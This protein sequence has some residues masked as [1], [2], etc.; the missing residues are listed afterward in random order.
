MSD[1]LTQ[2]NKS[3]PY[4]F[5]ALLS[6]FLLVFAAAATTADEV[7]FTIEE[8]PLAIALYAFAR[9]CDREILF[10]TDLVE[11]K[12][13]Q[14]VEGIYEPEAALALIL[15]DSG[16]GYSVTD[17]DTFLVTRSNQQE[18]GEADDSAT[19]EQD[20]GME[21]PQLLDTIVV[22]GTRL[23][24]PN[25]TSPVVVI[26]REAIDA[27]GFSTAE[28]V[29]RSLPQNFSTMNSARSVT[30]PV[31][32]NGLPVGSV[33]QGESAANLRALGS[34]ATLVLVNGR[35]T[36]SSAAFDGSQVNL[37]GIPA[38]AIDRVEV[39]LDGASAVYGSD[40]IG[41]V[42]NF[43]LRED[44]VGAT[45]S[46]SFENSSTQSDKFE[47]SQLAGFGWHGG[48]LTATISYSD[49]DPIVTADTGFTTLDY[50]SRGGPDGRNAFFSQPGNVF[51]IGALPLD[52]DGTSWTLADLSPANQAAA[53]SDRVPA[54]QTSKVDTL[55]LMMGLD[56]EIGDQSA[57]FADLHYSENDT[58]S[59]SGPP[60][61]FG[62]VP[63]N[64]PYNNAG[65]PLFVASDHSAEA[66]AGL[67]PLVSQSVVSSNLNA[68]AGV[69]APLGS[70][71]WILHASV[72][73]GESE[74]NAVTNSYDVFG[75][76]DFAARYNPFG[77][78]TAQDVDAFLE[79]FGP[80]D[81]RIKKNRLAGV[82]A[83]VNR[84]VMQLPGGEWQF[85]VG[86]ELRQE[87]LT[88][89]GDE[90]AVRDLSDTAPKQ[91]ISALY[92]EN[93]L[94]L[95]DTL[96]LM[97]QGRWEEYEFST[98]IQSLLDTAIRPVSPELELILAP[99]VDGRT[100][101]KFSPRIGVRWE[102]NKSFV[103]RASWGESFKAP[104]LTQA[105]GKLDQ[106]PFP[107]PLPF[108]DPI[109][110][111]PVGP[112]FLDS[113]GNPSLQPETGTTVNFGF[114]WTAPFLNGLKGSLNYSNIEFDDRIAA[115]PFVQLGVD[116]LLANPQIFPGLAYRDPATNNLI[117]ITLYPINVSSR[118]VESIDFSLSY[119]WG[120]DMGDFLVRV[121][122]TY[123]LD[124]TDLVAEG[125]EPLPLNGT[126]YGPNELTATLSLEWRR[127]N[128]GIQ[129]Y[130]NYSDSYRHTEAA[131]AFSTFYT[132]APYVDSY[133]T[134]DL[135]GHYEFERLRLKLNAGVRNL[136]EEDYPFAP[137]FA[138]PYDTRRVDLRGRIVFLKLQK[139]F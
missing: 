70:S 97:V 31:G 42:M 99:P 104:N 29:V 33:A 14:A 126:S 52:N 114:S 37:S 65:F 3:G 115:N 98:S 107:R 11:G 130:G 56:Q 89:D 139:E 138:G 79:A 125:L 8:Q 123:S 54:N 1:R 6:A 47:I 73:Y 26:T 5:Q 50:R 109:Q 87:R 68:N 124:M 51:G 77:N 15:A 34:G 67:I 53:V 93:S 48:N 4:C 122:G 112:I 30:Q 91:Q 136:F 38:A 83:H 133:I 41:G 111:A 35:R 85:V 39:I 49:S 96:T 92:F 32:S 129:L 100:Y 75:N 24:V 82:S 66:Q 131:S 120:A 127:A 27:R 86:G 45:T 80:G 118:E 21:E 74:T 13:A 84:S 94:P 12:Q 62:L 60:F 116:F 137:S 95:S 7:D 46:L 20:P 108:F 81:P 102:A 132:E 105:V 10:S 44:Y 64:N 119:E 23:Q 36:V 78:G 128:Y 110:G 69:T 106:F 103:V 18:P 43:V 76:A 71:G 101:R 61:V 19:G 134:W 9:Q 117:S 25:Q 63:P 121:D 135:T 2:K 90:L 72:S 57:V 22:T 88:Q 16:L 40:A 17:G 59:E 113:V 58:F 28:D 55:S